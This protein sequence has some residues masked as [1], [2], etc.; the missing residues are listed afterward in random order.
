MNKRNHLIKERTFLIYDQE[1]EK[2]TISC[3]SLQAVWRAV[4]LPMAAESIQL[5]IS[6]NSFCVPQAFSLLDLAFTA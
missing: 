1:T 6:L 2:Q 5:W 4:T 3:S